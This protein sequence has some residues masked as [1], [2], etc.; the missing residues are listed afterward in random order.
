MVQ[1]IESHGSKFPFVKVTYDIST[2]LAKTSDKRRHVYSPTMLISTKSPWYLGSPRFPPANYKLPED[3]QDCADLRNLLTSTSSSFS[4][5]FFSFSSSC[6]SM[7]CRDKSQ[8]IFKPKELFLL[9]LVLSCHVLNYIGFFY[10]I[11]FIIHISS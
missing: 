2:S 10:Y 11:Y 7:T 4:F 8:Q 1:K 6:I 9:T 3:L 5:S